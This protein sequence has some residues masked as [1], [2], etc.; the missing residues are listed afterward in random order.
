MGLQTIRHN[1]A[2]F[3]LLCSR[4]S[5]KS[6]ES[7][8]KNRG[9]FLVAQWLRLHT[10]N[11]GAPGLILRFHMLQLPQL[12]ILYA[13]AKTLHSQTSIN[14]FFKKE[15]EKQE[16]SPEDI[17]HQLRLHLD[18]LNSFSWVDTVL[19]L[20]TPRECRVRGSVVDRY[21]P[22]MEMTGPTQFPEGLPAAL[23]AWVLVISHEWRSTSQNSPPAHGAHPVGAWFSQCIGWLWASCPNSWGSVSSSIKWKAW[24]RLSLLPF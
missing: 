17:T 23:Q 24:G 22:W 8:S 12:K 19:F 15:Y 9:T 1:W 7:R 2:T 11:A 18:E 14:I 16:L 10:P 21:I 4:I 6:L 13:S 20:I 5:C 3:T